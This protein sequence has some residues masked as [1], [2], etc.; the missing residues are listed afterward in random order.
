MQRQ[1]LISTA[2][3]ISLVLAT[4]G[5]NEQKTFVPPLPA[6][7]AL[8][9]IANPDFQN[10]SQ[11]PVGTKVVRR[12][13]LANANGVVRVTTTLKLI[14]NTDAQVVVESQVDVVRPDSTASNPPQTFEFPAEYQVPEQFSAESFALPAPTAKLTG[15]ETVTIAGREFDAEVYEW[16]GMLESGKVDLK[17]WRSNAFPGRQIT[18]H[19]DYRREG[20][21]A[22][23]E[24]IELVI[25]Q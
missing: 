25:P 22:I 12:K 6:K 15:H 13:E 10:W 16:E 1:F 20:E 18:Q 4:A 11:F 2:I 5:C 9:A 14:E 19:T 17:L 7:Q 21:K 3:L 24:S 23:E 8:H